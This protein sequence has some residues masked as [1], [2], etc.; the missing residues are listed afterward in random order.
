M[1]PKHYE[2]IVGNIGT[3]YDGQNRREA[4]IH[5]RAYIA[6]S[7][8][9]IGRASGEPVTL[10]VNGDVEFEFQWTGNT[11]TVEPLPIMP[12]ADDEELVCLEPDDGS[13]RDGGPQDRYGEEQMQASQGRHLR[14][15]RPG[16]DDTFNGQDIYIS[17]DHSTLYIRIPLQH[18]L[19]VEGGC[20]CEFCKANPL[21]AP[22]W[23]V[24]ALSARAKS[25]GGE[26]C[27]TIHFPRMEACCERWRAIPLEEPR[28][29]PGNY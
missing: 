5:V 20:S 10:L 6:S 13:P 21:F 8:F 7:K 16:A 22:Q 4:G 29:H 19:P 27:W 26:R 2:V 15:R 1:K 9:P 28:I 25:D 12:L 11:E 3:V 17:Q 14:Q 18:Q 24:I 23:D